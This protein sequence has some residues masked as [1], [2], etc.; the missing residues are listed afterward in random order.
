MVLGILH[1]IPK[2]IFIRLNNEGNI[3]IGKYALI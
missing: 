3:K 1:C 2:Y